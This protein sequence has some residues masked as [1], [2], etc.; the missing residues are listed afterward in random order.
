MSTI[1]GKVCVVDGVT[2]DKVFSDDKQVYGRNLYIDTKDFN[3][4]GAWTNW[5]NWQKTEEKINGLTVMRRS[6][7]WNGLGQTIQAKKGE[8]Y[9]FSL[10]ARYES[11]TGKSTMYFAPS[12]TYST[13]PGDAAFSL[14]ETWQRLTVTFTI[15][16]DGPISPRI[17]RTNNNTNTLLIAG[18]KPEKG[19]VATP[20]SIAPEDILK[21]DINAP[22]NLV[23]SQ[24]YL[25]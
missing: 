17:E 13:S 1:N 11:G 16:A 21:G 24:S 20:Y 4:P 15:T 10:Y 14:N 5:V 12:G 22:K 3:N 9:T 6:G 2:V 8:I 25:K 19:S 23:E 7:D 18:L